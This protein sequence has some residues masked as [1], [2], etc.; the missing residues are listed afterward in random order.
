MSPAVKQTSP[1]STQALHLCSTAQHAHLAHALLQGGVLLRQA[2]VLLL[3][4]LQGLLQP[5]LQLI[6][7][8]L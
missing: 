3:A 1:P 5:Q 2:A 7:I 6:H 4:L 8:H